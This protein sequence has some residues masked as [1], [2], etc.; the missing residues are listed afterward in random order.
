MYLNKTAANK[1]DN[2]MSRDFNQLMLDHLKENQKRRK[3]NEAYVEAF[4]K[5]SN[6]ERKI[7]NSVELKIS[8][9]KLEELMFIRIKEEK[10]QIKELTKKIEDNKHKDN[11]GRA[12]ICIGGAFVYLAATIITR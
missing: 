1:V 3:E 12:T 7:I 2:K 6:E 9:A 11:I 5:L 10:K 4:N 8:T